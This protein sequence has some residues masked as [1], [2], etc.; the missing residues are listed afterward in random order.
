MSSDLEAAIVAFVSSDNYRRYHK[1]G[2]VTPSDVLKGRGQEILRRRKE[3]QAQTIQ[4]RRQ[5]NRALRELISR[6]SRGSQS[7][8]LLLVANKDEIGIAMGKCAT[9]NPVSAR[10]TS[11]DW[12]SPESSRSLRAA[13]AP[14]VA[15]SG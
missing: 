7:V 6:L 11:S 1:A 9:V 12:P 5:H 2:N 13:S 4:G 10:L 3:V 8:P 15:C 14:M